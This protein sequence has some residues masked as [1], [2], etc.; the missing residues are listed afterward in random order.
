MKDIVADLL[1]NIQW[2][3]KVMAKIQDQGCYVRPSVVS[4]VLQVVSGTT[5]Q[6]TTTSQPLNCTESKFSSHGCPEV[7]NFNT[8]I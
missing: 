1:L 7:T 8:T 5:V 2:L 6:V 3:I 4:C